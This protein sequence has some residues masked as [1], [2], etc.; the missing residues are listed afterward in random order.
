M[1]AR[2]ALALTAA[3]LPGALVAQ[4]QPDVAVAYKATSERIISAATADK[5]AAWNTLARFTDYSGNRLS[6]S[7][8]LE[9]GIDWL[10]AEMKKDGLENVHTEPA[11]VPHWVRGKESATLMQPRVANLPMLG[12]GG[13]IATPKGGITAP[14]MVV[15]SFDELTTRAA[16][17]KGK[18]VLFDV[19][20][21]NYGATVAYRSG[22]AS[23]AAKVGALA[24][25]VRSVTPYSMRTP[26]TGG[27]N[28]DT[29]VAKIPT[30]AITVE[31]AMMIHRMVTRGE[32][33]VVKLEM[34]A[35]MLPDVMSRNVMGEIRGSEKPDEIIGFGGH[36]D[37][38]DVG[39][40]AMD[41][42]GGVIV[43]WEALK[44][45]KKLG[46][47]P[48]RTIRVVGWTNEENGS[49]GG[50]AYAEAHKN[51]VANH[52]LMIES[53]G[54]VFQPTQLGFSGSE[55]GRAIM[56]QIAALVKSVGPV[57]I[58]ASGGG[59]DIG[60]MMQLGVPGVGFEVD[61]SRYFWFHHTDADTVDK[62]DPA[63]MQRCVA[64]MAVLSYIAAD[65]PGKIGR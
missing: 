48:K 63:E 31:D 9:R 39:Q 65:L 58:G 38:R 59:A 46:L 28:Y 60:P 41:D 16:E 29:T 7:A 10:V 57:A 22:G 2:L 15:G 5:S 8:A 12:L 26:H 30:A 40:G 56:Q 14:V 50:R 24:A 47:K 64:I 27:M 11:M 37:S 4:G 3:L 35:Q 44:L 25:L 52:V 19:P 33:V 53:D 34:E 21:T 51:E 49:R 43:A 18:I 45:M 36:I 1:R 20:F 61:G 13:S 17:A 6:G 62:L 23:A 54:G 42:G 32:P 55:S